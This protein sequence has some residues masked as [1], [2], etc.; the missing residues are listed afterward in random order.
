MLQAFAPLMNLLNMSE[1]FESL[2]GNFTPFHTWALNLILAA[3]QPSDQ[4]LNVVKSHHFGA[5][6]Q[7]CQP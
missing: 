6:N 2:L 3:T 1:E 4:P 5:P 7:N